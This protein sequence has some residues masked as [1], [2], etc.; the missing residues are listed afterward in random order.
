MIQD[1]CAGFNGVASGLAMS[2][3]GSSLAAF[4]MPTAATVARL[5]DLHCGMS[6]LQASHQLEEKRQKISASVIVLAAAPS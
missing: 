2:V 5:W 6:L 3:E 1:S 4:I